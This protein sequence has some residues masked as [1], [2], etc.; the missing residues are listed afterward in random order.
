MATKASIYGTSFAYTG[1]D[2][3]E[4]LAGKVEELVRLEISTG[5][6][7]PLSLARVS[8]ALGLIE[9]SLT[10]EASYVATEVQAFHK[11]TPANI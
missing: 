1:G 2:N 7:K 3:F 8:I 4:C 11:H 10:C 9:A 5:A 6:A